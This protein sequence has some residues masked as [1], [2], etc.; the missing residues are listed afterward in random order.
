MEQLY[1]QKLQSIFAQ[2]HQV[3]PHLSGVEEADWMQLKE[4][5]FD[6]ALLSNVLEHI[7]DDQQALINIRSVLPP[8]GRLVMLVPAGP[9]LF[10]SLDQ[11]VGHFRRYTKNG[12]RE[13]LQ[14]SGFVVE[15]LE[16]INM[17]GIP[18]WLVNGRILQ[19]RT[20][21]AF[22]LKG[23]NLVAPLVVEIE[24]RFPPPMGMSILAVARVE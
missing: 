7:A 5:Q 3:I 10:G 14:D 24:K 13:L 6:F 19:R 21:T 1:Y 8:G 17:L 15:H 22:Q 23:Y 12:L 9:W 11:A 4:Y 16:S 2:T 18:D 20:L